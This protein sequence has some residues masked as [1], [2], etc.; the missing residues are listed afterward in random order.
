MSLSL[1]PLLFPLLNLILLPFF[2]YSVNKPIQETQLT[3]YVYMVYYVFIIVISVSCMK[4]SI[5]PPWKELV[6]VC[7]LRDTR[8]LKH[9]YIHT[10]T[11][12]SVWMIRKIIA[13]HRHKDTNSCHYIEKEEATEKERLK[14]ATGRQIHTLPF[15][16]YSSFVSL[17][18]ISVNL[19]QKDTVCCRAW[20]YLH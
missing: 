11:D 20:T 4:T 1:H 15:R 19:I 17:P 9:I 16:V 14:R 12:S 13:S 3:V 7:T 5:L 10:H 18:S 6:C 8:T 2:K